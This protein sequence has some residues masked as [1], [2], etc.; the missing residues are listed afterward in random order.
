MNRTILK[1]ATLT[2]AFAFCSSLVSAQTAQTVN[3]NGIWQLSI[4]S[5]N[6]DAKGDS[7]VPKWKIYNGDGT[8]TIFNYN[9]ENNISTISEAGTYKFEND[10]VIVETLTT[11]EEEKANSSYRIKISMI[12]NLLMDA[13]YI[14]S[15]EQNQWNELWKRVTTQQDTAVEPY[16]S[17]TSN[18]TTASRDLNG[19]YF[20]VEKMPEYAYGTQQKMLRDIAKTVKYP[21]S[22][23]Q[24]GLEGYSIIRFVVNEK[25][26]TENLQVVRSSYPI[27]D[28]EAQRVIKKI[29]FIP[30]EHN[31]KKVK[32]YLTLPIRFKRR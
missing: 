27:L 4:P 7:F 3:I 26:K 1:T 30:G 2:A 20:H 25:G 28:K 31:G 19:V 12:G 23:Q 16:V 13:S 22:A 18:K 15:A 10:S 14:D 8:F 6:N 29:K 17:N 11:S 24:Q 21:E 9:E 32:V 5:R